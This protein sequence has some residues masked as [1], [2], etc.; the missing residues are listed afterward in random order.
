M[1]APKPSEPNLPSLD[2]I[3]PDPA[4]APDPAAL[5]S[6][7]KS[8]AVPKLS[9]PIAPPASSSKFRS[10]AVSLPTPMDLSAP[11]DLDS[12]DFGDL[13]GDGDEATIAR[14]GLSES[15]DSGLEL[16]L[17]VPREA[18]DLPAAKLDFDLPAPKVD[19]D[20][21]AAKLDFD[22]PA[23]KVDADL[24]AAKFDFDLPAPKGNIDLPAPRASFGDL[25]LPAPKGNI[26]LPAPRAASFGDLDLPA[27]AGG[28]DLPQVAGG[29]DLPR[30]AAGG[31]LPEFGD[32]ELP[33]PKVRPD[34]RVAPAGPA[35]SMPP[36][37]GLPLP[38]DGGFDLPAPPAAAGGFGDIALPGADEM[39][40]GDIPQVG[41]LPAP[42]ASIGIEE[43]PV[44]GPRSGGRKMDA[45]REAEQRIVEPKGPGLSKT[46]KMLA[47]SGV[48]VLAL[49]G[50]GAAL[51]YTPFG[52]FGTYAIE[53][54]LPDSGD[55]A[56]A[57]ATIARAEEQASLDTYRDVRAA[58]TTLSS[59]RR[60]T[61]LQRQLLTR[62]I[63]HEGLYQHRF[64]SDV[65]SSD[66]ATRILARLDARG[67][68]APGI[69]LARAAEALRGGRFD[70]ALQHAARARMEAGQDAYVDLVLGEAMLAKGQLV[71]AAASFRTAVTHRAGARG[72][73][74]LVRTLRKLAAASTDAAQKAQLTA[75]I[76][77]TVD[78]IL[79]ESPRH[80]GAR[81]AKAEL[82][83]AAS[84]SEIEVL[85]LLEEA[86]GRR[87]FARE[88]L[89]SSR[90]ERAEALTALG[91]LYLKRQRV[92]EAHQV[93]EA[94][95]AL[96]ASR[97]DLL[98]SDGMALLALNR[99]ADALARFEAVISSPA[100]NVVHGTRTL[101]QEAKLGAAKALLA[102]NRAQDAKAL[103]QT[104]SQEMPT[105]VE[106]LLTAGRVSE[107]TGESA[108][109]EQQFRDVIR[110]A[111]ERFDGYLALAHLFTSTERANEAAAVLEEATRRVPETS[112]M[113]RLLGDAELARNHLAEA[114]REYSRAVELDGANLAALFGLGVTNRR[115]GVY[116]AASNTFDQLAEIEP[117][118]P[119]LELERGLVYEA[120]GLA[121][122]AMRAYEAALRAR[123][124][125]LDLL[126]RLGAAQ[127]GAGALRE[128]EQTL[129]HVRDERP[130]SAE[131]EH[132]LGRLDLAQGSAQDAMTHLERAVALDSSRPEFHLYVAWT[133]RDLGNFG[134]ALEEAEAA[135]T[136]DPSLGDAY[137]IR[138]EV[139]L[140]SGAVRDALIDLD[141]AIMLKPNRWDAYAARGAAFVELR[142]RREAIAAYQ[143]AVAG[144]AERGDWWFRLGELRADEGERA[145]ALEALTR[146]ASIGD[147][148]TPMPSWLPRTHRLMAE[149]LAGS[150]D[151][152]GAITHF[153][154]Y[155][156]IAP[157]ND[158]DRRDVMRRLEQIR[159]P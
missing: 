105:D 64:G 73:W 25:D 146:A 39:E 43:L 145:G 89:S 38:G 21:P 79:A 65:A 126:L 104:L 131:V 93:F 19:A 14:A 142:Q 109:A 66:R 118:Y 84:G 114:R 76:R 70:E 100:A 32:L 46:Q 136:R 57:A 50:G 44:S 111:P 102:L 27:L 144:D 132:F 98:V 120:R 20:L 53:G 28:A 33:A 35:A 106:V 24:P 83:L 1:R 134:K 117:G 82:L 69:H 52:A 2:D 37:A 16:D 67:G 18:A 10:A 152:A 97:L 130:N 138:G 60:Q 103:V 6:A 88:T 108:T 125:D 101:K 157:Q 115:D 110:N 54:F 154:R 9:V 42:P 99:H 78:A 107:L 112:D 150:G 113:R 22:L 15:R 148:A 47:A 149:A 63:V 13:A 48:A 141:R 151:R 122:E 121:T 135:I 94:A 31:G 41:A 124:G 158:I 119:N 68:D 155:L 49:V 23:P 116:E 45:A 56:T 81:I 17:P 156:E 159:N 127:V 55:P 147:V 74:G 58:L 139:R 8:S 129:S 62:S 36:L 87:P 77:T 133:A 95:I 72:H 140:R 7:P 40:F 92:R 34:M 85:T 11:S 30:P 5:A 153:E 137:W 4:K 26:D 128:A 91:E 12:F 143:R 3:F 71:D 90:N 123:P 96:D 29:A 59:A 51:A 75:E 80:V 86:T 61:G